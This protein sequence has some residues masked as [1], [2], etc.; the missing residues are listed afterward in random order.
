[1]K[2]DFLL[3]DLKNRLKSIKNVFYLHKKN[4]FREKFDFLKSKKKNYDY[5]VA[6]FCCMTEGLRKVHGGFPG[7]FPECRC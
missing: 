4:D 2:I 1:M 5:G 7:D 3:F 6:W